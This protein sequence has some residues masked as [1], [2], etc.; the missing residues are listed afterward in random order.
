M[1][2]KIKN[3]LFQIGVSLLLVLY[4]T[5]TNS[6]AN[7]RSG[8]TGGPK[9]TIPPVIVKNTPIENATGFPKDKGSIAILFNE[10]V[11]I[12]DAAKNILLS[13]PQKK[14]VK[15]KIKGKSIVVSF[16]EPLD[17]NTT[18]TL[19]FGDAIADNNEGNI[20]SNYTYSFSTGNSVDSL[21]YSG[22]ILDYETLLPIKG[23]K[24]ALYNQISDTT[25]FKNLPVAVTVSD[26]WGYFCFRNLKAQPYYLYA[27]TDE[28]GNNK[29]D[30]GVEKIGFLDSTITPS[31]VMNKELTQLKN[32]PEKDTLNSLARPSE[33]YIYIFKDKGAHQYIKNYG[34]TSVRTSF[35]KFNAPNVIIDSFSI[36]GIKRDKIIEEFNTDRD[37]LSFWIDTGVLVP[38]TLFLGIKYHKTDSLGNLTPTVEKLKFTAPKEKEDKKQQKGAKQSNKNKEEKRKDLLEFTIHANGENVEQN[39]V[40]LEFKE[41]LIYIDKDSIIFT[42]TTP[43]KIESKEEFTLERDTTTILKYILKSK[44]SLE[45]GNDYKYTILQSGIKDI[46]GFTND[47]TDILFS[48][49][50]ADIL[51]SITTTITNVN[52]RYIIE[53]VNDKRD[54]VF[55]KHIITKDTTL[56]FPY[57]NK[58]DYSIRVTQDLNNNGVLDP[59]DVKNKK[60]PEKV[61][62][63]ALPNGDNILQV[64]EKMDIEQHIDIQQIFID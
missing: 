21:L 52:S 57:L 22:T 23:V 8:P 58:G 62:L 41:P 54:K 10:Y 16:E 29:Y 40:I 38:D 35:I 4:A 60:Q 5:N 11:Q 26:R 27:F 9:D 42:L 3:I 2:T 44:K 43:K 50:T 15:S 30:P 51:S 17:S 20:L 12:K 45:K 7:T 59:G 33:S 49:P 19:Y 64:K 28:N 46:N 37:S 36:R 39:G 48:L 34:R 13:P 18:Y 1:L 25:I 6:C 55:R 31:I 63:Y 14:R 24:V 53:L 47:S 61:R 56:L 32:Y